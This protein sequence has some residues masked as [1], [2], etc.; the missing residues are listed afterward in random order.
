MIGQ[1]F[2]D[3]FS[4]GRMEGKRELGASEITEVSGKLVSC[5][6]AFVSRVLGEEDL[7]AQVEIACL[8]ET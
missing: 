4:L 1:S 7:G 6:R 8:E 2:T 3:I 5:I